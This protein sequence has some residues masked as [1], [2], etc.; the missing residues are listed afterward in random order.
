MYSNIPY[1]YGIKA[2]VHVP[3]DSHFKTLTDSNNFQFNDE[4]DLQ[5]L[6]IAMGTKMASCYA[7]LIFLWVSLRWIFQVLV[8]QWVQKRLLVMHLYLWVSLRCIFMVPVIKHLN[9]VA[10]Y[11]QCFGTAVGTKMAPCY[12]SLFMGILG[13]GFLGSCDKTPLFGCELSSR[14]WY[15]NGYK[16]GPLSCIFIYG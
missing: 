12:A 11:L 14:F 16:N 10:N 1:D 8:L 3:E 15:C 13:M 6:G 7:S 2:L 5:G 9:L 4:N